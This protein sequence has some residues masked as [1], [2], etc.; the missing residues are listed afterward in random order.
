M[1]GELPFYTEI[2]GTWHT[3]GEGEVTLCGLRLPYPGAQ[4]Q[5]AVPDGLHCGKDDPLVQL[6]QGNEPEDVP[7]GKTVAEAAAIE[8]V[9][10][11][12]PK[13]RRARAKK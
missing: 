11:P 10:P 9:A 3:V 1:A 5:R 12:K 13:A 2:D 7:E 8:A 4:W 6:A